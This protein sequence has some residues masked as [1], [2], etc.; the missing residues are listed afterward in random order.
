MFCEILAEINQ[1]FHYRIQYFA[2]EVTKVFIILHTYEYI[3]INSNYVLHIN[4]RNV[5]LKLAHVGTL[6]FA[7][8][9]FLRTIV[10]FLKPKRRHFGQDGNIHSWI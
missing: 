2:Y 1:G 7:V 8:D 3:Y 5:L 6:M 10:H 9:L 4:I